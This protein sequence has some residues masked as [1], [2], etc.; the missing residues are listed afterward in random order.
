[1]ENSRVSTAN[2]IWLP[3]AGSKGQYEV[4]NLGRVRNAKTGRILKQSSKRPKV[5]LAG[6]IGK[7]CEVS[8]LVANAFLGEG[9]LSHRDGNQENNRADNLEVR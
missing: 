6:Y 9:R 2:E 1:M 8:K 7:T 3:I 5:C 4:S